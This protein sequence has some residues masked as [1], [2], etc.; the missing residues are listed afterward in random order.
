MLPDM[1]PT[2]G[3]LHNPEIVMY[4]VLFDEGALLIDT[5]ALRWG[6]SRLGRHLVKSLLK[7]CIRLI[8]R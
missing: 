6:A 4:R 8:D 5:I 3:K 1:K 7:L 2:T